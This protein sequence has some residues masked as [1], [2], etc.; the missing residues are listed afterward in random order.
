MVQEHPGNIAEVLAVD[1]GIRT[2]D[3]KE[4]NVSISVKFVTGWLS[5]KTFLGVALELFFVD[6]EI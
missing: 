6:T 4:S 1:L 3:F 5:L 2:T